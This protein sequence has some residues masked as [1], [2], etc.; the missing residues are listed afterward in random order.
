MMCR[1]SGGH[2]A[3]A[4]KGPDPCVCVG[5]NAGTAA[6]AERILGETPGDQSPREYCLFKPAGEE[7]H[8]VVPGTQSSSGLIPRNPST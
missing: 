8:D 3:K 6:A 1:G 5:P 7:E 4:R 2:A